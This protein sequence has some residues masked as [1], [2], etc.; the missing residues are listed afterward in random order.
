MRKILLTAFAAALSVSSASAD[1]FVVKT[2]SNGVLTAGQVL[3]NTGTAIVVKSNFAATKNKDTKKGVFP[4]GLA[5]SYFSVASSKMRL[6]AAPDESTPTGTEQSGNTSFE[7]VV[8]E[9]LDSLIFYTEASGNSRNFYLWDCTN[10]VNMEGERQVGEAVGGTN[11]GYITAYANI[12]P[13]TY[14]F[15]NTKFGGGF[16]GIRYSLTSKLLQFS[17][18]N[19]TVVYGSTDF[20]TPELNIP[21]G[22]TVTYASSNESVATVDANEGTLTI[23]G[24]GTTEIT[25]SANDGQT[26]SYTLTVVSTVTKDWFVSDETPIEGGSVYIDNEIVKLASVY[27][28]TLQNVYSMVING[29]THDRCINVRVA[30]APTADIPTGTEQAGSTPLVLNVY[31]EI[32]L[33][34]WYRRQAGN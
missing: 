16:C 5:A 22:V 10:N 29:I 3:D 31:K 2:S 19:L 27:N 1:E 24:V 23:T 32:T 13:G 14:T 4:D 6:S 15:Y 33:N 7:I 9:K 25:A 17:A 21:E 8:N 28:T 18:D 20:Q 11:L 34:M 26:A 12:E 30:K